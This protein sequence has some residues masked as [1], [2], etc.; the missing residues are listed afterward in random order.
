MRRCWSF[1]NLAQM[2]KMNNTDK[3]I[4]E[5]LKELID[6][7]G[8]DY[9]TDEPHY[10]YNELAETDQK[11]TVI[12]GAI[13]MLLACGIWDGAKLIK[14]K[15]ELSKMI[16]KDCCFN[17][18]MSDRLADII[19]T[20]YSKDNNAEWKNKKG[21]GLKQFLAHEQVFRW[22]GFAVWDAGNCTMDCYYDADVKLKPVKEAGS[23]KEL[24]K[25][26]RKNPFLSAS[27]IY[28]FYEK[29]LDEYLNREFE[30]YCTCDDYYEPVVEDFELEAYVDDWCKKNGFKIISCE[31]DGRDEGYEPK[32]TKGWY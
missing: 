27:E 9:L 15:D 2:K 31:G 4:I 22:E 11:N 8:P 23:N 24:Q 32:F 20:L 7:N 1:S 18:K 28:K 30:E 29:K 10:I 21:E 13:L 17:K 12:A 16:Q 5:K 26:L 25:K 3:L 6:K 19:Q 14:D